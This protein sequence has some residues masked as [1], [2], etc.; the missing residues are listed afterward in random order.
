[1]KHRLIAALCC[2][3][4]FA[5]CMPKL[6]PPEVDVPEKYL[7]AGRDAGDSTTIPVRWWEMFCDPQLNLLV[8]TALTNNRDLLSAASRIAQARDQLAVARSEFM[9]SVG[10]D[11]SAEGDYTSRTE[12]VQSYAVE[13]ALTWEV[14][15]FGALRNT[16]RAARARILASE[17]AWR[18]VGLSLA[19][20]VATTYFTLLQYRSD[21]EIARRSCGLRRESAA[22]IDSMFRYGM[23][24][25]VA[26]E[27][28][29]SLVYTAEADIPQYCRAVEQTWLSMGILLGETPSR[30]RLSGAGLRLLTDYR[31]ADIP[32]GL[33]SEL[34]KRRPDI[35]QAHF[36]ML[37]A[38]AQAGQA[39]SARFPSISLTAKGGVASSSI[40]GLTAANPWAW[41]ALGSVAEPIFGFGKLR[42]AERAAMAAYTQSAK[43]YEQTVLT[44]FADVEKALVA[45]ATYRSQTERTGELVLSN[46]RIATMTRALY[47]SG[48][49]D[50]LDVIDAERSLYQSQMSHVNLV[51]QQ[52][53]N[54]VTLCKALGGGWAA[55]MQN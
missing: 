22:L 33:P 23:S 38:A 3:A 49:S 44:A 21:L 47:R 4:L 17:W 25:G 11:V 13:P 37:Q 6:Y 2:A 53:I 9:P 28:A 24:D 1:M 48:L 50:Y 31:P 32:V 36:N 18:G 35:R 40:K 30:A 52:Y 39:R 54:Y 20:E 14:S 5:S 8:E 15:L 19:A 45:I 55:A 16:D 27:Q 7:H 29:R 10:L 43:T 34:L 51:V 12:I 26:L 41:D 42:N 46:D